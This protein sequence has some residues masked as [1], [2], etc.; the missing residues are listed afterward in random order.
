MAQ[1]LFISKSE[2]AQFTVLSANIDSDKVIPY[3]K[4]AQDTHIY[5]YLGSRLFNKISA[6][7]LAGNLTGDYKIL[8]DNYIKNMTIHWAMV[9]YIPFSSVVM[10]GKGAFN[11]NSENANV[12][13]KSDLDYLVEKSRVIA[14]NYSQKFIDYMIINY[15][16]FPEYYVAQTGDQLPLLSANFGG[17]YLPQM[18][19]LVQNDAGDI[20][21]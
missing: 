21:R 15:A 12:A 13:S 16:K 4:I 6:D 7:I 19:N 2:L 1:P 5:T 20:K 11:H 3:I 8:F 18:K 14:Q 9:E 17:W 10:S